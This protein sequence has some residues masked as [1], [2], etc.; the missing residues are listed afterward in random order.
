MKTILCGYDGTEASKRALARTAELATAFG[1][2]VVVV[3]V[4]PV[5]LST[6]R[7]AGVVD[8]GSPLEDHTAQ[9]EEARALLA[10][11]GIEAEVAAGVGEPATEIVDAATAAQADLIV[12]GTREPGLLDRLLRGS[13]SQSVSR[14]AH[15]DVL[16]VH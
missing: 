9:L 7:G 13:V 10:E 5:L 15:C 16:I 3:S 6:A 2:R 11:R 12:V 14:H 1:S 4:A 8:P